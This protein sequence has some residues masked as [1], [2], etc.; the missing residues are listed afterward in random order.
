MIQVRNKK[1]PSTVPLETELH[2]YADFSHT[3]DPIL[4]ILMDLGTNVCAVDVN[5]LP[6]A[7]ATSDHPLQHPK[8]SAPLKQY[9]FSIHAA[10]VYQEIQSCTVMLGEARQEDCRDVRKEHND[11]CQFNSR[12]DYHSWKDR[13]PEQIV[14]LEQDAASPDQ[15]DTPMAGVE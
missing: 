10:G 4:Y 15:D 7:S 12:F 9:V 13:F 6:K 3:N 2:H 1:T 8:N 14:H 5:G 11:L